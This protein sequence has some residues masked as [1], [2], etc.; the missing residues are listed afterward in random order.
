MMRKRANACFMA[1]LRRDTSGNVIAIAAAALIPL[2]GLIGGGVDMSR[3]YLTKTRL[4][5]ACD[6]GALA[7]RKAMGAGSWTTAGDDSAAARAMK[8]FEANFEDRS[9]GTGPVSK[10]FTEVEGEVIGSARVAVPMT[11]MRIF[12]MQERIMEVTCTAKMEIPNTDVMFVLDTTYSMQGAKMTG[13]K[14]AV[15][16]FYEALLRVNTPEVCTASD[17]TAT[18]Y[19]GTAQIRLGF[20]PYGVNVNV[21]RLLAHE[22]MASSW[23]YQSR[24]AKLMTVYGWTL[25]TMTTPDYGAWV[26]SAYGSTHQT[27]GYNTFSVVTNSSYQ[28]ADGVTYPKQNTSAT[29]TTS[30]SNLNRFGGTQILGVTHSSDGTPSAVTF[31]PSNNN[32]PIHPATTQ[33]GEASRT[34]TPTVN[35]GYRYRYFKNGSTNGC[36]LERAQKKS[37]TTYTQRQTGPASRPINW[38]SYEHA[39]YTYGPR[40]IDLAGLR[41]SGSAWATSMTLRNGGT[42]NSGQSATLSGMSTTTQL[43]RPRDVT[44]SWTG[45]V[46]ERQTVQTSNTSPALAWANIPDEAL[47]MNIDMVPSVGTPGS[48][49]GPLLDEAVWARYQGSA[50]DGNRVFAAFD[51]TAELSQNFEDRNCTTNNIARKLREYRTSTDVTNFT[52]YINGL[53]AND[54]GTYH[55]SGMLWG[56]RLLSPT[57]IFADENRE[58]ASG[59]NIQRHLIFMTDGAA[60]AF[61]NNYG[62]YGIPFFDR[63]QTTYNPSNEQLQDLTN[64]RLLRLCEEVKRRNI[65]LWVIYYGAAAAEDATRLTQCA[66]PSSFFSAADATALRARFQQIAA[67]IADLRLTN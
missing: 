56:A 21:G 43:K 27:N 13:L 39:Y 42:T 49:W 41:G 30:C 44:I 14:S 65:N 50:N 58:T 32:P 19:T 12:N 35:Y 60:Q 37:T 64:T 10:T 38:T 2:A 36:W 28:L 48:H 17:P 15:K 16:C 11:M 66:S 24:E 63:R 47:D 34:R 67:E 46:E 5:Q 59:G 62:L 55:D 4:Q 8:F 22:W 52:S 61:T 20:V 54:Y 25:G 51:S 6:A 45:C 23:T 18:S 33:N 40:T 57:G 26:P 53:V 29:N 31:T 9:F 3:M 7:G 1:R